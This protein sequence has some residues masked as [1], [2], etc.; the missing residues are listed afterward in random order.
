MWRQAPAADSPEGTLGDPY[1][2]TG[3]TGRMEIRTGYGGALM[4]TLT[5]G[6]GITFG[7]TDGTIDLF[8]SGE[9]ARG[10]ISKRGRYDLYVIFPSG[11]PVR[12][13]EGAVA[14]DLTI[15]ELPA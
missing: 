8:I 13:L 7:G 2:L 11:E 5:D 4:V 12:L 3:C 15:S 10:L 6:D 9:K 1:D 14:V